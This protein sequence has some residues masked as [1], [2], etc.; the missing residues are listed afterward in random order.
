MA[1]KLGDKV[2][3]SISGFSGVV[4]QVTEYLYGCRRMG[5]ESTQLKD[6]NTIPPEYFDE[7]RL[8]ITPKAKTGGFHDATKG[9]NNPK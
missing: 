9:P 4:V 5:V 6:G 7:Q 1:I 8:T 3:D 2:T